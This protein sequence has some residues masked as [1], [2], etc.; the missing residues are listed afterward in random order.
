LV[1]AELAQHPGAQDHPQSWQGA[2]GLGVRVLVEPLAQRLLQRGDLLVEAGQQ[3]NAG[4]DH[5]PVGLAD[6]LGRG[7]LGTAQRGL[8]LG[9]PGLE[10]ALAAAAAKRRSDLG[11]GQLAAQLRVGASCTTANPSPQ[12]RSVPKASRAA[13]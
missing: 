13:G 4:V 9:R 1:I 7:Q 3:P 10:I 11:P 5:D 12:A 8:D 2:D 6:P